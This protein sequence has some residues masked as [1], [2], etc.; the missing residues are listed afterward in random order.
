MITDSAIREYLSYTASG[1]TMT[2]TDWYGQ[3]NSSAVARGWYLSFPPAS[4]VDDLPKPKLRQ[5]DYWKPKF[6][7]RVTSE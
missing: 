3:L 4:L 5:K 7:R 6:M 1:A 2:D